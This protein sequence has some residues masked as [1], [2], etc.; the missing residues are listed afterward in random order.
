MSSG[1]E[2]ERQVVPGRKGGCAAT[3]SPRMQHRRPCG[4]LLVAV[5]LL[6]CAVA[7]E[8]SAA[9]ILCPGHH[10]SPPFYTPPLPSRRVDIASSAAPVAWMLDDAPSGW[11]VLLPRI[12]QPTTATKTMAAYAEATLHIVSGVL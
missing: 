2:A 3:A 6:S 5:L 7:L 8:V 1:L 10:R 9:Y 4:P 12:A 11:L